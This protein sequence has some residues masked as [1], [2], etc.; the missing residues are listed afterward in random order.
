MKWGWNPEEENLGWKMIF[1]GGS[2]LPR[3]QAS[4]ERQGEGQSVRRRSAEAVEDVWT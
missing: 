3:K 1:S 2:L 4:A